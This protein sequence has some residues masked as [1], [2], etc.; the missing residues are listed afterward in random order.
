MLALHS[1]RCSSPTGQRVPKAVFDVSPPP[2]FTDARIGNLP[3]D[4]SLELRLVYDTGRRLLPYPGSDARGMNARSA[5]ANPTYAIDSDW[6]SS[7]AL[8]RVA[9]RLHQLLLGT[10]LPDS[11]GRQLTLSMHS[12]WRQVAVRCTSVGRPIPR[13][14][15]NQARRITH[16]PF[17]TTCAGWGAEPS[18]IWKPWRLMM[19]PLLCRG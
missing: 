1:D 4:L 3:L 8:K 5:A 18:S 13:G 16:W 17:K 9:Q 14:F 7:L 12:A 2:Y 15:H 19:H 10:K 11:R 6:S